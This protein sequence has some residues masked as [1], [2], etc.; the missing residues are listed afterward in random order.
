MRRRSTSILVWMALLAAAGWIVAHAHYTADL[1]AFLPARATPA[2]QA[3]VDELREGVASRLVL[4]DIDGG[5]RTQRAQ[6][7]QALATR[8]RANPAFRSVNNGRAAAAELD[9]RFIFNHRY[10]LSEQVT[11]EHFTAV[12]LRSAISESLDALASSAGFLAKDLLL[13]DPTGETLQVLGQ[14]SPETGPR[15]EEGVWVS[16]DGNEALL[17]AQTR[18]PGGDTSGQE[19]AVAVIEAEFGRLRAATLPAA[20][21][22]R[23][24]VS[25]PG[26]FAVRS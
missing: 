3:L 2:Q 4:I 20:T 25:G 18:V 1:S 11:P 14:L 26:V 23:L 15:M 6:L 9:Q 22:I 10:L 21:T 8:L 12:G 24:R 19:Q 13:T 7:S 16:A 17:V 5:E